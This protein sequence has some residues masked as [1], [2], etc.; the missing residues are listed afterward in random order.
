MSSSGYEGCG[1]CKNADSVSFCKQILIEYV[2]EKSKWLIRG[3]YSPRMVCAALPRARG[4]DSP[5]D[6]FAELLRMEIR[7]K[8]FV[9]SILHLCSGINCRPLDKEDEVR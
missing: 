8:R 2:L 9:S 4:R 3:L 1:I 7:S 6:R 5:S